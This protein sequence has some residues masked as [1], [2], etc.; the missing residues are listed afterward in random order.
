MNKA[1]YTAL[2]ESYQ[3][4]RLGERADNAG[5][6][7][8]E[9][10]LPPTAPVV[11]VWPKRTSLLAEIWLLALAAGAGTRLWAA[12]HEA[13]RELGARGQR[14]DELSRARRG[15]RAFPTRER[16]Q[17][18]SDLWRFSAATCGCWSPSCVALGAQLGRGR[19][20]SIHAIA[21]DGENV[22]LVEQTIARLKKPASGR[23][24]RPA[25]GATVDRSPHVTPRRRWPRSGSR[26]PRTS[27]NRFAVDNAALRAS[28][29]I[30]RS[31]LEGPPIRR[32]IPADQAAADRQGTRGQPPRARPSRASSWSPARCPGDG[33]TFTS[34]NLALSM[35]LE[36]DVSVLLI[37]A[38]VAKRH[39]SDIFGLRIRP[40]LLDALVD[41]ELEAESAIVPTTTRGFSILP[42]GTPVAG[43]EELLSSNRMRKIMASLCARNPRRVSLL[44]S[45]AAPGDQRGQGAAQSRGPGGSRGSRGSNPAGCDAGRRYRCSMRNR[46][47]AWF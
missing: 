29:A 46:R 23:V 10:V 38:D 33:K 3:K 39:I 45:S 43:T 16:A 8:F 31:D 25:G 27:Q 12:Y 2:L 9:I 21:L 11:P 13:D 28:G 37:D 32:S 22:S 17:A 15:E 42:A 14:I 7:R 36:R 44:D 4:A 24:R 47:A 5:S 40:G 35:A 26:T 34:I 19:R 1:Q 18:L 41:E 6:V 30:S 20:L